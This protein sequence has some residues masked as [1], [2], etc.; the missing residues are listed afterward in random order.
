MANENQF[1][2]K[3]E[4]YSGRPLYPQECIDYLINKL[5]LTNDSVIADIGAGTGILTKAFLDVG[6]NVYAVEPNDDMFLELQNNLSGYSNAKLLQATAENTNILTNACDAVV[7]GTA[8]HWFDK[9]KFRTECKRILKG[10]KYVAILRVGNN[11]DAD[12]ELDKKRGYTE[13]DLQSAKEFFGDGFVEHVCFEYFQVFNE[14]R[15]IKNLL[16]SATAPLPCDAGFDDYVQKCKD[17][18]DKHF[19]NKNANLPFAVNC[20]VGRLDI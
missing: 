13:Q 4:F 10:H 8:F 6:Y 19:G 15:F 2:G 11:T 7:V 3:A 17:T 20:F 5:E 9:E 12:K 1:T 18:F 14:E 16:S